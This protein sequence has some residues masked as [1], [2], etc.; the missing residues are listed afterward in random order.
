MKTT[1]FFI[2]TLFLCIVNIEINAQDCKIY[3]PY[4][5]G[6]KTEITT[7]DKKGKVTGTSKSELTSVVDNGNSIDYTMHL[8]SYDHKD[9][10]QLESDM[11]FKCENGEFVMDMNSFL[12]SEQMKA[13]EDMDVKITSKAIN[14]PS[15][16]SVG[17]VLDDGYVKIHVES[18][19]PVNMDFIVSIE[20]RKVEAIEDVTTPAGTFKCVKVSEDIITKSIMSFTMQSIEWYAEGVGSVKS[21][22]YRDGKLIGYS[23][24]T[25][26]EKP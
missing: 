7:Y 19:S 25:K 17:D 9:K 20:N 24:L 12:N 2:S 4:N 23:E 5:E 3:V 13:Y 21:E 18:N 10:L 1:F 14:I 8:K 15:S 6:T 11:N 22:S 26:F 16:C